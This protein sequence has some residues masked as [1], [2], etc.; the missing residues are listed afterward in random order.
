MGRRSLD[1]LDLCVEEV[2]RKKDGTFL[3]RWMSRRGFVN[4]LMFTMFP[5]L[6]TLATS[7]QATK[8]SSESCLDEIIYNLRSTLLRVSDD[9]QGQWRSAEG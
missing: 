8:D 2:R 7:R 1:C 6:Q 5:T 3:G 9:P 4:H